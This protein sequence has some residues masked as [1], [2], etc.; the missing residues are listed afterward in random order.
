MHKSEDS[1]GTKVPRNSAVSKKVS[2]LI[3]NDFFNLS[4]YKLVFLTLY[5]AFGSTLVYLPLY[6]KY[7]GL[8][9]AQVG[10]LTGIRPFIQT[11]GAPIGGFLADKYKRRKLI[12]VISLL[13]FVLKHLSILMVHPSHQ[14]CILR[15]PDNASSLH[16]NITN[17][18]RRM[19]L[20][21]PSNLSKSDFD[22]KKTSR[23]QKLLSVNR[24]R[25]QRLS[26]EEI[27]I[28][29]D[30]YRKGLNKD[31]RKDKQQQPREEKTTLPQDTTRIRRHVNINGLSHSNNNNPSKQSKSYVLRDQSDTNKQFILLL[32]IILICEFVGS[33]FLS[34]LDAATV[35]Y[36]DEDRNDYGKFRLWGSLG[37]CIAAITIGAVIQQTMYWFCDSMKRD[38]RMLF[39]FLF[40]FSFLGL[41]PLLN[42]KHIYAE[43]KT[44]LE[45]QILKMKEIFW[46]MKN[47]AFWMAII[48]LGIIDGFQMDFGPWFLDDLGTSP[49]MIGVAT[50]LHFVVN[51]FTYLVSN[52]IINA[53]GYMNTLSM[54]LCL[55]AVVFVLFSFA[56]SSWFAVVLFSLIGSVSSLTWSCSITYVAMVANP[57]GIVSTAEGQSFTSPSIQHYSGLPVVMW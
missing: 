7:L 56:Q 4:M 35:E 48:C 31:D 6:F 13:A 20:E 41:L 8:N 32:F 54:G 38:Y 16:S 42:T 5:G 34:L 40:G 11:I 27:A 3:P 55:Y 25:D 57:V 23:H 49:A 24:A 43:A 9:A 15:M 17:T 45:S 12:M 30:E 50:A 10:I 46:G 44:K 51:A 21:T 19:G 1:Q 53:L 33:C 36:L 18:T 29:H 28:R 39:Y 2:S 47:M 52:H 37:I 14:T 22:A 26:N